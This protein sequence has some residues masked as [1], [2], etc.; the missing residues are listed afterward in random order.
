[1]R[2]HPELQKGKLGS[3]YTNKNAKQLWQQI[4]DELNSIVGATK[5]PLKWK[6]VI[7]RIS[8]NLFTFVV[9]LCPLCFNARVQDSFLNSWCDQC[10][11]FNLILINLG[12]GFK[13]SKKLE[14]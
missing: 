7:N 2:S 13:C 12:N 14:K 5:D 10:K 11:N 1:M 9:Y 6:K 4:S 3:S 8:H